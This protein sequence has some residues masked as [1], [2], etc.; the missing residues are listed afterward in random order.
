MQRC[1]DK[2]ECR[3]ALKLTGT[4]HRAKTFGSFPTCLASCTLSDMTINYYKSKR[5]L[6][7]VI[8]WVCI[9]RS[10]KGEIG[11]TMFSKSMRR[12][13][14]LTPPLYWTANL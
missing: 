5:L 14:R 8:R 6:S 1:T 7:N 10:D 2:V 3:S 11:F 9:G 12:V 13:G 4:N